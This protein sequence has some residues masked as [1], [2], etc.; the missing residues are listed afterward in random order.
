M[1]AN[2][3]RFYGITPAQYNQLYEQQNG[4]CAICSLALIRQTDET[5][6]FLGQPANEVGRVDHDHETDKVR[7]LLCFGCNVGLGKF[8]DDEKLLLKAVGYLCAS[9]TPQA[10]PSGPRESLSEI[11]PAMGPRIERCRGSRREELSPF[12]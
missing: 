7:G 10:Q 3:K 8:R 9:A 6:E 1:K 5:R 11:E 2:F 4:C 12:I